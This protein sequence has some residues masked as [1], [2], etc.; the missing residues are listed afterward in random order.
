[1]PD[2]LEKLKGANQILS[3]LLEEYK[4]ASDTPVALNGKAEP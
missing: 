4:G 1:M 2:E 3:A